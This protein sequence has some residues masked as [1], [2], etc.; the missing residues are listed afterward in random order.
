MSDSR[1]GLRRR[2]SLLRSKIKRTLNVAHQEEELSV[3]LF[4]ALQKNILAIIV[5]P[6]PIITLWSWIQRPLQTLS[7]RIWHSKCFRA[8]IQFWCQGPDW[9]YSRTS[10]R[11][12]PVLSSLNQRGQPIARSSLNGTVIQGGEFST[13]LLLK[14]FS[15]FTKHLRVTSLAFKIVNRMWRF[16][17]DTEGSLSFFY[18]DYAATV[19]S[20]GF[21]IL[22][23]SY[24][25]DR[26]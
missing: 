4:S 16:A 26:Y 8:S 3:K 2:S 13:V 23:G 5:W 25:Q 20:W 21:G 1:D 9:L 17:V 7:P 15:S 6:H 11:T 18:E 12:T 24:G 22:V 14:S 19:L 10:P